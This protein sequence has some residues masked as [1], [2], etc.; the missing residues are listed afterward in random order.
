MADKKENKK[1]VKA[2]DL[3]L[4]QQIANAKADLADKK[5][6]LMQGELQNP[7]IMKKIKK[8]IARLMTKKRAEELSEKEGE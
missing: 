6:G 1:T 5:R 7:H 4:D 3:T 8:D 2:A